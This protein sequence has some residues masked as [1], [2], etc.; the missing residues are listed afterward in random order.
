MTTDYTEKITGIDEQ[1]ARL[2][3]RRKELLR[4]DRERERKARTK[5]L[6]ERGAIVESVIGGTD[7]LTSDGFK[8]FMEKIATTPEARR[9]LEETRRQNGGKP[10]PKPPIPKPTTDAADST[11]GEAT[12]K[13]ED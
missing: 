9:A 3:N 5:R 7:E 4:K 1:I 6:I 8:T 13:G 2:E 11:D 12:G 10:T